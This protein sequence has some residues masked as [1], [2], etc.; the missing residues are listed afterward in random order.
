MRALITRLRKDRIREKIPVDD[1]LDPGSPSGNQ[2]RTRT[3]YSGITNGT[4]RNDLIRGNYAHTDEELPA[5]WGYQNVGEIVEVGSDV[6]DVV[7]AGRIILR[8]RKLLTIDIQEVL[9]KVSVFG[10]CIMPKMDS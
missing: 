8:D 2:V 10:N 4:E 7:I 5:G 9:E 1:W 6:R 3:V